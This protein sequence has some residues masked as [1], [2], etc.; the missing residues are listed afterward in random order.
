VIDL[1]LCAHIHALAL[2]LCLAF[3]DL[4]R[5]LKVMARCSPIGE[6]AAVNIA[7]AENPYMADYTMEM[8]RVIGG[9]LP[10]ASDD[11]G[12]ALS[13]GGAS[14]DDNSQTYYFGPSTITRGKIREM[15]EK[16]YFAEGKAREP[17]AEMVPEPDEDEVIVYE[18]FFVAGLCLPPHPALGDILLSFQ[19][20]LHQL[21]P[22]AMAQLSKYFWV[23][24][25]FSGVPASNAFVKRYELHY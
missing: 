5:F 13:V 17:G 12:P 6:I 20:Q 18:D 9:E 11:E 16:G 23:V 8:A 25:S 7:E 4:G 19:V 10:G 24:G 15:V 2:L 14:D 21:S 22:N 3:D 1:S